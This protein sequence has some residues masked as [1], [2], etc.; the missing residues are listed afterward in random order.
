MRK[1]MKNFKNEQTLL[2]KS[3]NKNR[4]RNIVKGWKQ[5]NELKKEFKHDKDQL[6]KWFKELKPYQ[7]VK[8]ISPL[9]ITLFS[10]RLRVKI[11]ELKN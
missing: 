6:G 3:Q 8:V 7:Q 2:S 10:Q 5:N 9:N 1:L 4:T 11:M